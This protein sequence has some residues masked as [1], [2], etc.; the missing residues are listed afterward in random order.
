MVLDLE[1]QMLNVTLIGNGT[2][3]AVNNEDG[4]VSQS[5]MRNLL[6]RVRKQKKSSMKEF[7]GNMFI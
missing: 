7:K 2:L 5:G 3:A 4:F 1:Y 6:S